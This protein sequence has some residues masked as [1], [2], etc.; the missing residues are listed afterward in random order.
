MNRKLRYGVELKAIVNQL[1]REML[2]R[3]DCHEGMGLTT[4]Q[5]WVIEYLYENQDKEVFQKDLEANFN[6]RRSTATGILQGMERKGL[7]RRESVGW[8]ARLKKLSLTEEGLQLQNSI[9]HH[10][11]ALEEKVM[12]D[13]TEEEKTI[14]Y[15]VLLKIKQNLN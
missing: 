13:I 15:Q 8:D 14:F 3:A 11:A 2:Q 1:C 7:I 4:M 10:L 9:L 5:I 6:V 12:R